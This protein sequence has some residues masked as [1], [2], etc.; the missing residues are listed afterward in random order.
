M[1]SKESSGMSRDHLRQPSYRYKGVSRQ[2][3]IRCFCVALAGFCAWF[4]CLACCVT[5]LNDLST[6]VV[7][8]F[9]AVRYGPFSQQRSHLSCND[10]STSVKQTGK[11]LIQPL[12]KT[13]ELLVRGVSLSSSTHRQ[14]HVER[15]PKKRCRTISASPLATAQGRF[16]FI[17]QVHTP[18]FCSRSCSPPRN[19]H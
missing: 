4:F 19:C 5:Q 13:C 3:I 11:E 7:S 9:F 12:S 17:E 15:L 14:E 1:D 6:L 18:K 8:Y 2:Y 10:K 16:L